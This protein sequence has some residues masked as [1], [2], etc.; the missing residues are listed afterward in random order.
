MV[1]TE[2]DPANPATLLTK[3]QRGTAFTSSFDEEK[4][5]IWTDSQSFLKAIQSGSTDTTDLRRMLS[6][7][8][9]KTTL[10]WI[11][12]HHGIAGNEEAD[13]CAKQAAAITDG[14]PRP[15]SYAAASA[16]IRRTLTDPLQN[17]G[18]IHQKVF[19]ADRLLGCL[20]A[21][22]RCSP[23]PSTSRSLPPP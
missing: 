15:V 8:A 7:R 23:R 5:A 2:G 12:G 6:K 11:P 9:R 18:S 4:A 16:L 19:M 14:A 20:L 10:L 3:Q 13:A 21:T 17:E 1:V 22:R